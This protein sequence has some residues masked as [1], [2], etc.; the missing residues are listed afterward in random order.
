MPTS[1]LA[2]IPKTYPG[3]LRSVRQVL[4]DGQ[5]E[6]DR[7]WVGSY[8]ETGR[9]ITEHILL[10]K[11]RADYGAHLYRDLARDTG[12]SA[13][14]PRQITR[15]ISNICPLANLFTLFITLLLSCLCSITA[16]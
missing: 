13:T 14:E 9:L 8:H 10:N 7:V 2:P 11:T 3:L 12:G 15:Q 4:I 6:I 5:R 1:T 16:R